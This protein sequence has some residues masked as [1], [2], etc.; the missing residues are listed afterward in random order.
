MLS[1]E[2]S[3]CLV[4]SA[5]WSCSL[6]TL[7][8]FKEA[9]VVKQEMS[10]PSR[11]PTVGGTAKWL[12]DTSGLDANAR[13]ETLHSQPCTVWMCVYSEQT[14]DGPCLLTFLLSNISPIF[15]LFLYRIMREQTCTLVWTDVCLC[16]DT[17]DVR[18]HSLYFSMFN[19]E[20]LPVD[21]SLTCCPQYGVNCQLLSTSCF[22]TITVP[23][24]SCVGHW[25]V[26]FKF[27]HS[28]NPVEKCSFIS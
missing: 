24:L 17:G 7:M 27:A 21:V 16:C 2:S 19:L 10:C 15:D 5:C 4:A 28:F 22:L 8:S 3:R 6:G 26:V 12:E 18:I 20:A 11:Y 23:R 13:G 9:L 1:F 14:L 25:I